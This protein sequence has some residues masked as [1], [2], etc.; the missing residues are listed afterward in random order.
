MD[1]A[2]SYFENTPIFKIDMVHLLHSSHII[3]DCGSKVRPSI[4]SNKS[5]VKN[6]YNRI[7]K[8]CVIP[9]NPEK[10][11]IGALKIKFRR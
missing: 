1:E 4:K 11:P 7:Q 2:L 5:C 9:I 8:S 3:Y 10:T 6:E